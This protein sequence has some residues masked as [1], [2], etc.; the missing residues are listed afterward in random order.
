METLNAELRGYRAELAATPQIVVMTKADAAQDPTRIDAV[1][2]H[3][4]AR[5]LPCLLVSSVTGSGIGA[6]I[7]TVGEH[8]D[9]LASAAPRRGR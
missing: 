2:R 7:G 3:A 9:R 1:E 4:A 5:G 6:L 8:L